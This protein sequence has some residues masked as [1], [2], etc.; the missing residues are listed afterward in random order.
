VSAGRRPAPTWCPRLVGAGLTAGVTAGLVGP[1]PGAL[2]TL[3][4]A[5]V[6]ERVVAGRRHRRALTQTLDAALATGGPL[7]LVLLDLDGFK[8]VNDTY[9]HLAGDHVLRSVAVRLRQAADPGMPG[10]PAGRGRVRRADRER[11]PA[12]GHGPGR[13]GPGHAGRTGP[14]RAGRETGPA[15]NPVQIGA[16]VGIAVRAAGDGTE[17]DLLARA[18]ATTYKAKVTRRARTAVGEGT[19][20]RR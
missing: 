14:G 10:C 4:R 6:V 8:T 11:R 2:L 7:G 12:L 15:G 17:T 3:V 13:P 20:S 19:R 5:L 18:D 9:G 16:S 1:A